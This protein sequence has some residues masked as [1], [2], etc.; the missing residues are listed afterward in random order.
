MSVSEKELQRAARQLGRQIQL[1]RKAAG[2]TQEELER[3]SG[4]YDVGAIE[5]GHANPQLMT[6]LRLARAL[7][8][9]LKDIFDVPSRQTRGQQIRL[10]AA[11]LLGARNL[12]KQQK[13]LELLRLFLS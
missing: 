12:A 9:E 6:Y 4:V 5:R 11:A 7:D 8:I 10:E 2:M 1:V 3:R 13:A